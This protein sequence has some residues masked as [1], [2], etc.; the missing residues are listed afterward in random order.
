MERATALII[1][2][3]GGEAGE[4]T[5]VVSEENLP[6]KDKVSL[7]ASRLERI[8]GTQID[9][10]EVEEILTRLGLSVEVE[11]EGWSVTVPSYRFDISIESDL[12]EEVA[13]I[14]GYDRLPTTTPSAA[15]PLAKIPENRLAITELRRELVARRSSVMAKRFSGILA[16]GMAAEGEI[17]EN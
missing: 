2:V 13:R 9:A 11:A 14:Y 16:N 3:C 17:P 8:L 7:R 5:E 4:I 10:K 1:E 15:I 6:K 12:V